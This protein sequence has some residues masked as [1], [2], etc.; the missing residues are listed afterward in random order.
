MQTWQLQ[1]AKAK[2]STVLKRC[3]KEP[4]FITL[5]GEEEAVV[6]NLQEYHRLIGYKQ[7]LF[8][9][10]QKSPLYGLSLDLERDKTLDRD[11]KL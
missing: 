2:L 10:F 7:N 9:F 5:R 4:Q 6:L 11:I 3:K 8:E 1:E